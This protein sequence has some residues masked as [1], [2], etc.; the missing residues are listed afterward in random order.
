MG[1]RS[2]I[3]RWWG[4]AVGDDV[5]TYFPFAVHRLLLGLLLAV[6]LVAQTMLSLDGT[7]PD[8]LVE[9]QLLANESDANS[10]V[11]VQRESFDIAIALSDWGHG[12]TSAR[13]VRIARALLSQRLNVVTRSRTLTAENVGADYLAALAALDTVILDLPDVA[14]GE[15]AQP[16]AAAQPLVDAFLTETRGLN[17]I[18]QRLGRD[19]IQLLLD[20]NRELQ[21]TRTALQLAII[22]MISL[23]ALS[24]VLALTR[25]YRRVAHDLREQGRDVERARRDLDLVC[26]LDAGVAPLLRAVDAGAPEKIVRAGLKRLLDELPTGHTWTVPGSGSGTVRPEGPASPTASV[27]VSPLDAEGLALVVARAQVV[28]AALVRRE[29]VVANAEAARRRDPLTGLPNR[30]GFVHELGLLLGGHSERCVVVALLNIDRFGEVSAALGFNGADLVLVEV[31]ERLGGALEGHPGAV[32]ARIAA[33]EFAVAVR[34]GSEQQATALVDVLMAAGTYVSSAGGIEAAISVSVGETVGPC[35]TSDA[36]ELMRQ[37]AG[38]MLLAKESSERRGRVRF[39]PAEHDHL[40][41]MLVDELAVR[42]ALRSG[43]FVTHYQPIVDLTTSRT[44][45]LESLVRWDR[46]GVGLVPPGEFLPIIARSGFVVEFGFEILAGVV[47]AWKRSL[48]SALIGANSPTGY[49][50]VNIDAAQLSDP[51]FEAFVLSTLE[52]NEME[53][54]ELVLELTEHS[55][56]DREHAPTLERLRRAGVRIA[57]DDFGSGFSSLGQSA[58]LPV[59]L[60]KLDRSFVSGMLASNHDARLFAVLARLA[61]TLDMDLVAEGIETEEVAQLLIAAGITVGQGFHYSPALA[62]HDVVRWVTERAEAAARP[63]EVGGH[64]IPGSVRV[65]R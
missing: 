26:E 16:L 63:P 7:R 22:L 41:T 36:H 42:N 30:V 37:A 53:P 15:R 8:A 64:G 56:V 44:L 52:R 62:E 48:R 27:P 28:V 24:I 29:R 4:G 60:L 3:R 61:T 47:S 65:E 55:V 12:A 39:D 43:E 46:P 13:E 5:S 18:V 40:A 10:V 2:S 32:L 50:S 21:R 19:Q 45:G 25:G 38:A 54:R 49:V 1:P 17:E 59:D 11:A 34:I 31:S 6:A 57:I 23:L 51:G 58:Q 33:D 9:R 35:A 14:P 20:V